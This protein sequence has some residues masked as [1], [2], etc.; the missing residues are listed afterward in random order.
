MYFDIERAI[1]EAQLPKET[2]DEILAETRAEFPNEGTAYDD[3]MYEL[4]VIRRLQGELYQRLGPEE[5]CK[6]LNAR[7]EANR[8]ASGQS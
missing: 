4:H 3:H 5:W 1:A 8:Q 7:V 6:R 2:V